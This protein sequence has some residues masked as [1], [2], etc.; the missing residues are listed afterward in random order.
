MNHALKPIGNNKLKALEFPQQKDLT[1]NERRLL[2][3]NKEDV[4]SSMRSCDCRPMN[5][6]TK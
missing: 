1:R 4:R 3:N 2:M 5:D 6:G